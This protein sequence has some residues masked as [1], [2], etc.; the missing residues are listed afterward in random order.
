[1]TCYC[2]SDYIWV[3]YNMYVSESH[4]SE[5]NNSCIVFKSG[6]YYEHIGSREMKNERGQIT[7]FGTLVNWK[8]YFLEPH[9]DR[10][11]KLKLLLEL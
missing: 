4:T 2:Y 3:S 7:S 8:K 6:N 10:D 1:M 11:R 9:E 5:T